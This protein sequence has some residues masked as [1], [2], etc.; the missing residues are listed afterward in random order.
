MTNKK[1]SDADIWPRTLNHDTYIK[2]M[3]L[4]T[5][6]KKAIKQKKLNL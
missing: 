6:Y 5:W 1:H 2:D 3:T 4:T